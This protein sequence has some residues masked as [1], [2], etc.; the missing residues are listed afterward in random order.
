MKS[1]T[2]QGTIYAVAKVGQINDLDSIFFESSQSLAI[3][4]MEEE[5]ELSGQE[6]VIIECSVNVPVELKRGVPYIESAKNIIKI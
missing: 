2:V 1:F 6:H 3:K 5:T 4:R